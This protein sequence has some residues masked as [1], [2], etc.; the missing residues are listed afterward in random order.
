MLQLFLLL[1]VS[2]TQV[3]LSC[4]YDIQCHARLAGTT[5]LND[6]ARVH[7]AENA[8]QRQI[9]GSPTLLTAVSAGSPNCFRCLARPE[10]LH[11]F[12][13]LRKQKESWSRESTTDY[14]DARR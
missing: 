4:V 8:H 14:S 12:R 1:L 11:V 13:S 3:R 7:S 10:V 5:T 2:L 9:F 6:I